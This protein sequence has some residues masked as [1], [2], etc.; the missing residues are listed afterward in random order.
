M[1]PGAPGYREAMETPEDERYRQ[2]LDQVDRAGLGVPPGQAVTAVLET[3]GEVL[4][5]GTAAYLAASLPDALGAAV[6][7]HFPADEPVGEVGRA[8]FEIAVARRCGCAA[9]EAEPVIR[10]VTGA[11]AD[12]VPLGVMVNVEHVT[13][14]PLL[15]LIP[16]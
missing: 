9:D 3:L 13:P 5:Y 8:E 15:D 12:V 14:E 10:A 2:V 6:G 1:N 11:V 4:P 16:H 7:R